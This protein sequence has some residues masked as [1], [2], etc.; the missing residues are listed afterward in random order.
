ME[1]LHLTSAMKYCGFRRVVGTMWEMVDTNERD[2]A[3]N[4]YK[5]LFS[6][7]DSSMLYSER[8]A[9]ALRDAVQKLRY[10]Q[11]I[12]LQRWVHFVRYGQ[13]YGA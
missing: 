7:Q 3:K 9:G 2:L 5:S 10:K 8:P 12:T 6:S 13:D 11:G 4:F 1:G